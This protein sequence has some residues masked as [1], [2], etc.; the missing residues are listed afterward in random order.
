MVYRQTDNQ[1]CTVLQ[2]VEGPIEVG[3]N[4]CVPSLGADVCKWA[5]KLS[6]SVVHQIVNLTMPLHSV[7]HQ[8]LNLTGTGDDDVTG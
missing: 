6:T 8:C 7:L 5:D 4:D 2:T 3:I 1:T